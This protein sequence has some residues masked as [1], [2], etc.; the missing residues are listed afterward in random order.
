MIYT[1]PEMKRHFFSKETCEKVHHLLM[2]SF[3]LFVIVVGIGF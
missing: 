1:R 2:G 3:E